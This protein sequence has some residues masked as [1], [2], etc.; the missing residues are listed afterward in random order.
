MDARDTHAQLF[1]GKSP[2]TA[3]QEQF[4]ANDTARG[5]SCKNREIAKADAV[6]IRALAQVIDTKAPPYHHVYLFAP[7]TEREWIIARI[8]NV[9]ATTMTRLKPLKDERVRKALQHVRSW[10]EVIQLGPV[11]LWKKPEAPERWAAFGYL[12][13]DPTLPTWL[14][15][16]LL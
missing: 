3:D 5:F 8:H 15:E 6:L 2:P 1:G 13:T 14:T 16:G 10:L 11:E 12:K 4:Y 9:A 7:R